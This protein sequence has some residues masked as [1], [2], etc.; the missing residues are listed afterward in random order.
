VLSLADRQADVA[1]VLANYFLQ[2]R[3]ATHERWDILELNHIDADEMSLQLLVDRLGNR[4]ME[5]HASPE[6]STWRIELPGTADE[7]LN[8]LSKSHRKQLRQLRRRWIETG[9]V[10]LRT[11]ER[12]EEVETGWRTLIDLHQRRLESLGKEGSFKSKTFT[13]FHRAVTQEMFECGRLRLHW[14]ELQGRPIAAEY[15]LAG[16]GVMFAYQGGI[17]PDAL[18]YEPGR[19]I[20][21]ATLERA[22]TDGYRSFDFCRGD[23]PY[24]AHFRAQPRPNITWRVVS[25]RPASRLRHRVWSAGQTARKWLKGSLQLAYRRTK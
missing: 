17:D 19:L 6:P 3:R 16:D 18:E 13:Q 21:W 11:V 15:H 24:K 1:D 14:L 5:V 23:E 25:N 4:G 20:T 8:L 12:P 7:Y 22:I 2:S 10:V 9:E